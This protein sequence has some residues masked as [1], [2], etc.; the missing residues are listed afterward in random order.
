MRIDSSGN[1]GIGTSSP[2][3]KLD[4]VSD[5]SV[6]G[7]SQS[8]AVYNGASFENSI[9]LAYTG[10]VT[11][12]GNFQSNPLA[13]LT[14]NTE[15]MRI[16]SSGNVGIGTSS[17]GAKLSII[18]SQSGANVSIGDSLE[19]LAPGVTNGGAIYF[20]LGVTS[21]STPTG[22]I[23]A[24]WGS[25]GTLP[26]IHFGLTRDGAKHRYSAFY[27]ATLRM[28]TSDV[29]RMRI[30][31]SGNVG[32]GTSSPVGKLDIVTG[33]YRGYFDDAGGSLFRLNGVLANNSA[34][35]PMGLN[36]SIVLF[37]TGGTER[38]RIDSSGNVGIGTA[39]PASKLDVNGAI[40][41][42]KGDVR[43]IVQNAQT[44]AYVLVAADAGKHISI[45]TGG[46]TVNTSIFSAGDAISI[47][48]DSASNQTITQGA[49]VTMYLGGTATT[50]NRT[51]AQRGICTILCV[52]SN[53]FVIS[54]AGLT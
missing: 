43:T 8:W 49:S 25:A 11:N 15:R 18:P 3:A 33:T 16:T 39:S 38:A 4:V 12:F 34:Y 1:V 48:N 22:G 21:A 35:G 42:S 10:S 13:F 23:E 17:P 29:E 31:S 54:G 27:D 40:R 30:D 2:G 37:Q 28:Y 47:Y 20:G 14:N 46:V 32:V 45:T 36:G 41:D 24:S 6:A 19:G 53:T 5:R 7:F 52:A 44:G 51:L 26:Q 9:T 50:G